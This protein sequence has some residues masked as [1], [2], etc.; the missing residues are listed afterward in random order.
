MAH[1]RHGGH[2][3]HEWIGG[4][5]LSCFFLSCSLPLKKFCFLL[6]NLRCKY[7]ILLVERFHCMPEKMELTWSALWHSYQISQF[8]LLKGGHLLGRSNLPETTPILQT[9]VAQSQGI[10]IYLKNSTSLWYPRQMAIKGSK[11]LVNL[12]HTYKCK[13]LYYQRVTRP[14]MALCHSS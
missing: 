12:S 13:T 8:S 14:G 10:L 2:M 6:K 3:G 11:Q 5:A 4:N 1:P 7:W 9:P